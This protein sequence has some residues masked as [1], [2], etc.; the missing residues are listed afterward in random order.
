MARKK[1]ITQFL[2]SCLILLM[3]AG[4]KE[5]ID[6]S[7][8]YVFKDPTIWMYLQKH[9]E[10]SEYCH[11]LQHTPVSKQSESSISQLLLYPENLRRGHW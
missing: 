10:Y 5:E 2:T 11:V 8:R 3:A 9:E 1:C 7:A 6:E 4:C